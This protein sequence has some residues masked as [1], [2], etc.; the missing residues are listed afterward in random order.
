MNRD[1]SRTIPADALEAIRRN[2]GIGL[3]ADGTWTLQGRP[4]ANARVQALF[5]RGLGVR[6][7]G[8][9]VL[10]VGARWCYVAC[11]GVARFVVA[12]RFGDAG[13]VARFEGGTVRTAPAPIIG[14]A[15]DD[16][17]YLW[18]APDDPPALLLR[19]PSLLRRPRQR[20]P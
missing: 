13:L 9:V 5:H 8:E 6:A 10:S 20:T 17:L 19:A 4:V 1:L 14:Y 2:S 18:L 7:D 3:T 12:V 15:P 16:R 11:A